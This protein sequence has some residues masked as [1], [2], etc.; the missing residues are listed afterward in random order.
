[1]ATMEPIISTYSKAAEFLSELFDLLNDEFFGGV[2][3]KPVISI[4]SSVET[5]ASFCLRS[6]AWNSPEY[7]DQYA[8]NVSSEYLNRGLSELCCSLLH[9]MTHEY[10]WCYVNPLAGKPEIVKDCSRSNMY[11]NRKFKEEAERR[12]LVIDRDPMYGWT[13]TSPGQR[14]LDWLQTVQLSDIQLHRTIPQYT[15][16]GGS[17]TVSGGSKGT[18]ATGSKHERRYKEYIC[19]CCKAT[20]RSNATQ[21]LHLR[22][23]DCQ[24][25]FELVAP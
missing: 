23:E 18:S 14:L 21:E 22:C 24:E 3:A 10:N 6:D 15:V 17:G 1:M 13:I 16:A 2:L 25:L 9:E 11:H 8:L 5:Y 12:G 19:P 20:V 7:G 4:D